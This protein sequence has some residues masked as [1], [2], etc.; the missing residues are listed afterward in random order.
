MFKKYLIF[1]LFYIFICFLFFQEK[2]IILDSIHFVVLN[3]KSAF[4]SFFL[5]WNSDLFLGSSNTWSQAYIFP[6]SFLYF[7]FFSLFENIYLTQ[8]LVFAFIV[9]F[10][11]FSFFLFLR[12]ELKGCKLLYLYIS[13]LFYTFNIYTLTT[14]SGS[15]V[16]LFSYGALPL[17]LYFLKKI[18][19][20]K[21]YLRYAM[22]FGF[23]TMLMSGIN[24]PFIAINFF[25]IM[26]YFI[27]LL[28]EGLW[29]KKFFVFQRLCILFLILIL[30]NLYWIVGIFSFFGSGGADINAILS[31]SL[32]MQNSQGT[33]LNVFRNL[34]LWSFG[35]GWE[36]KSYYNYSDLYLNND[37]LKITLFLPSIVA[38]FLFMYWNKIFLKDK[39]LIW[40]LFLFS[41][42]IP[43]IVAT[44]EGFLAD[45]YNWAYY[46]IPFFSMFRSSYKFMQVLIF[47]LSFFLAY[48]LYLLDSVKFINDKK[49]FRLKI[50]NLIV[51]FLLIVVLLNSFPFF[52][53][54][55]FEQEKKIGEMPRYYYEAK[56]FFEN[57]KETYRILLLPPQYFSV[58]YWGNTS[59]NPEI[60]WNKG[61]VARQAGSPEERSNKLTL[62]LYDAL[63]QREYT[64]AFELLKILNV[65]YVVQ[66]NDYNWEFYKD[67]SK[68]QIEVENVLKDNFKKRVS[69]GELDVYEVPKDYQGSLIS[70]SIENSSVSYYSENS[71]KKVISIKNLK[72]SQKF[73]F[74]ESFHPEW[75][76]YLDKNEEFICDYLGFNE[77]EKKYTECFR[78]SNFLDVLKNTFYLFKKPIF[79]ETHKLIHGYANSWSIDPIYIKENFSKNFWK[80]N[81]DGSIDVVLTL[82]FKPQS[83]FNI[84][85]IISGIT[86]IGCFSYLGWYG[87]Q[88]LTLRRKLNDSAKEKI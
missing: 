62:E 18:F 64:K 7:F 19:F 25:V 69:F 40:T 23:A 81:S 77:N 47:T 80:E 88:K 56:N 84:G 37:I 30:M 52:T 41:V 43:M 27:Y 34:G 63:F 33:Y 4:Y 78:E 48:F 17:Q 16:T 66:R 72:N 50:K 53:D 71:V 79:K 31:E 2:D 8:A 75:S 74:S 73:V 45:F 68:S 12:Q 10:S 28:F 87:I 35:Q 46:N 14:F 76:L 85:F 54:R 39:R 60:I 26:S 70:T 24:P 83:Y 9:I 20:E 13:S 32:S 65:K 38:L 21:S 42:S 58:F 5:S 11:F 57:D 6:F 59:G 36:G 15:S 86:F 51:T 1:F 61:L 55:V 82:Y 49:I 22:G 44:K 67:I 29:G 3:P